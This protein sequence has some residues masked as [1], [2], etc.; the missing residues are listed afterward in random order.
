M[1]FSA[2]LSVTLPVIL[3]R[4]TCARIYRPMRRVRSPM[5]LESRNATRVTRALS[6]PSRF[7][8]LS[9]FGA[10][11]S[12]IFLPRAFI[13]RPS[14]KMGVSANPWR[15]W[16]GGHLGLKIGRFVECVSNAQT[17]VEWPLPGSESHFCGRVFR[18]FALFFGSERGFW[19]G[20]PGREL[21][22]FN[23]QSSPQLGTGYGV[24]TRFV[25]WC[26]QLPSG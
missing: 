23:P 19:G 8:A 10:S 21:K 6:L 1:N 25:H 26:F 18:G 12:L 15:C 2:S 7:R 13:F 9:G 22:T 16:I 14:L 17:L 3:R 24:S 20:N 4:L 11:A 5:P